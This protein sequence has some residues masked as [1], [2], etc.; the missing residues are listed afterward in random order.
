MEL[1]GDGRALHFGNTTGATH[2]ADA[3]AIKHSYSR[4]I[5]AAVFQPLESFNQYWNHIAISDRSHNAAHSPS[6]R[7]W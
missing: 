1:L 2:A 7:V 4:R 5:V 3:L 6:V